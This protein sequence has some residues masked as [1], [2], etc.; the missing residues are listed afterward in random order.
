M[1]IGFASAAGGDEYDSLVR[2][3]LSGLP[4]VADHAYVYLY[5]INEGA[6]HTFCG[7]WFLSSGTRGR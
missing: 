1:I 6:P 4:Q 3:N 5:S 7:T 2:F